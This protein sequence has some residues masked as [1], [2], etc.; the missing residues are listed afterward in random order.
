[1]YRLALNLT[2]KKTAEIFCAFVCAIVFTA[3]GTAYGAL[4]SPF[5]R[6]MGEAFLRYSPTGHGGGERIL[7][8]VVPHHDIAVGMMLRFYSRFPRGEVKRIFLFSPDHFRRARR[9][10]AVC[11]D[12][13]ELSPGT[14]A[15]DREAVEALGNM[16]IVELRSDMF[17]AEHGVTVHIPLLARFFPRASVVPIALRPDIPDIALLSLRRALNRVMRDGDIVILSADL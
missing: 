14:M 10:A 16:D 17:G 11:P 7:G 1:M 12:D 13:W 6:A 8:G 2:P 3:Y 5:D 15:A 4:R 9:W